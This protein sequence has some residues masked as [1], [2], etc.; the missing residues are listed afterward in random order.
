MKRKTLTS[1]GF[2]EVFDALRDIPKIEEMTE[3]LGGSPC[4]HLIFEE[5][6]ICRIAKKCVFDIERCPL[7]K[8]W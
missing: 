7:D 2:I 5:R 4:V 3:C 6:N 8:W 1:Q